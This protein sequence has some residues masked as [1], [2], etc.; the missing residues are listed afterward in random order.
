MIASIIAKLFRG[1][2]CANLVALWRKLFRQRAKTAVIPPTFLKQKPKTYCILQGII[3][4]IKYRD[5]MR[6]EK[7]RI[8]KEPSMNHTVHNNIVSF[9][10]GIADDVLRDVYVPC[11]NAL[12]PILVRKSTFF[13]SITRRG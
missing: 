2:E 13:R 11:N 10:W 4:T 5:A 9:I 12:I 1:V 6:W 8:K 3:Y 7:A